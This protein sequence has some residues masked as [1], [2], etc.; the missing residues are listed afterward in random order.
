MCRA[1]PLIDL[2]LIPG[3]LDPFIVDE[4]LLVYV[5]VN[6]CEYAKLNVPF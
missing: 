2:T 6:G 5:D 1:K 3:S 4:L